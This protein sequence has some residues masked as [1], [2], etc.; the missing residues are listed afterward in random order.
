MQFLIN[1]AWILVKL[2][3]YGGL[4]VMLI[5]VAV[6]G[7]YFVRINAKAGKGDSQDVP[8]SSWRGKGARRGYWIFGAGIAM[9][10]AAMILSAIL[11]NGV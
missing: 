8:R 5:G 7:W 9:Q 1:T 11:P 3:S 2:F 10:I 4:A 6:F